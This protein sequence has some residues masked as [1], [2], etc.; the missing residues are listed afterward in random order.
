MVYING[1]V[2][3]WEDLDP[4][5]RAVLIKSGLVNKKGKIK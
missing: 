5:M 2:R 1:H 4:K 3:K